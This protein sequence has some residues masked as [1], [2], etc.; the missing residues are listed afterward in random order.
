MNM[1]TQATW[2]IEM[3]GGLRIHLGDTSVAR[4]ETR[5]AASLLARADRYLQCC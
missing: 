3:F 4:F 5:R 2:K 1:V